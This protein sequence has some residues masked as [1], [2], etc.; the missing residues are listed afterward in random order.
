M[1]NQNSPNKGGRPRLEHTMNPEWYK[2]IVDAG[3]HGKHIT[4]FLKELGI[5][6]E[7]HRNLLKRNTKYL[8]AF[9]EYQK[10]CEEWWYNIAHESM[11]TDGGSKFNSRLWTIIVKNKFRDNWRDEKSLDVTTQGD[12]IQSDNKIQIEILK[13]N[14]D[15]VE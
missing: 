1:G 4:H 9:N 5:S 8:E 12:K 6:W 3:E 10:R 13:Q 11:M 14:L 2:I 7:S 15:D